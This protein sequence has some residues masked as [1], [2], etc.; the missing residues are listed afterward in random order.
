[1]QLKRLQR[2]Q[3]DGWSSVIELAD[4]TKVFGDKKTLTDGVT[5][6]DAYKA[7]TDDRLGTTPEST[8]LNLPRLSIESQS[9]G[10]I[11]E[12]HSPAPH[13]TMASQ[14]PVWFITAASS[15]FG[16]YV[17]LEAL[18]RGHRVIA[19]A[20]NVDKIADLKEAG[21]HTMALDVTAPLSELQKIA[22]EANEKYGYINHLMNCAGYI[23]IGAVEETSPEEDLRAFQVNVL[24]NLNVS[25]AFLPYIR[26]TT[27]HRTV[28]LYGSLGSWEGG[29][30]YG[31][32]T[33]VKFAV[34]GV[35]ESM[36]EELKPLGI[37][38]TCIEPGYFRTGFLN[39]GARMH[40][41]KTIKD[42]D[43]SIVGEMR[44]LIGQIDNNQKG[45]VKKGA[46]VIV[47]VLTMSGAAEGK[48][49]PIRLPLG[50]DCFKVI[51]GKCERTEKL[52]QELE[53]IATH[54]DHDG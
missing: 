43:D 10:E 24:G 4:E 25:K 50:P 8:S 46:K 21:A 27:G 11:F 12:Q 22:K 9:T 15:G 2:I 30:G 20:R 48:E 52:L 39:P 19:S 35:A 44:K 31:I 26:A 47:D 49:V 29:A 17:A 53:G 37:N 41:Q 51:R 1:M 6:D 34:S 36:Y 42:Y 28:S 5:P 32:Y 54:T 18:S 14:T 45:D 23:L 13:S 40:S 7:G 3:N 16:K 38:V 33:S